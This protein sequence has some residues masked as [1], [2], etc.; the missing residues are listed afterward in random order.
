MKNK[1]Q[2]ALLLTMLAVGLQAKFM[3][4]SAQPSVDFTSTGVCVNS[5]TQ[6][7]V[8]AIVTNV[9]AVAVWSWDLGDGT[10][11]NVQN[12]S[13]TYAGPGTY[14]V[15]LTI[16]DT[17]G[18]VGSA[19][20]FVTIQPLPIANFS[21]NTPN[22]QNEPIQFT[23]LSSTLFGYL[24]TWIWNFGD[25]SPIDTVNFPNTP[26]LTHIFPTFGTY[27]VTLTVIN[28][29]SCTNSV[30]L[31][32]VVTPG[33]I[34]NFYFTGKCEDQTVQFNDASFANGAGNIVGWAWDFG[35][36]TSGI[37]NTSN[38]TDPT[39]VFSNAGTYTVSLIIV[40]FNNCRDT[41]TKQVLVYP[42]PPVDFTFTT[43]CLNELVFFSPDTAVTNINAIGSWHWDFGDGNAS[44][45][46]NTA[47]AY[48]AR[49]IYC[50]S[51]CYRYCRLY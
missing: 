35:D 41:M 21:Y 31:P 37:N 50:N 20:H 16:T 22:C 40:N 8:D 7:T 9:N 26:N 36:P 44:N 23:D 28:S 10:F 29:D 32:V 25:G 42:H 4:L 49:Y 33:P 2:L 13:N 24:T 3:H 19:T 27:N 5:P 18:A 48:N 47:N 39:H 6:F 12:P 1:I 17:A 14:T 43:A 34:A 11:S 45:A 15:I 46:K 30:S 51:D 38:L